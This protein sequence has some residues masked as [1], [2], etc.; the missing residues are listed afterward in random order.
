MNIRYLLFSGLLL[1]ATTVT[2]QQR[3]IDSLEQVVASMPGDTSKVKAMN[4]LVTKLQYVNPGRAAELVTESIALA[5]KIDYELGLAIAYRLRGV[6]YIDRSI[7]DSGKIFYDKAFNIV[8]ER[9]ERLYRRQEGLLRHN[10][11]VIF[12][13]RQEYD[14][15]TALYISAATVYSEIGEES[16]MFYP[17]VN[18]T[19]LYSFLKDNKRALM[20]AEEAL[21]AA[22]N[23]ND[24][25]KVILAINTLVSARFELRLFDN[26]YGLI[27]KN[28]NDAHNL[29]N[30]YAEGKA[31][32]LLAQYFGDGKKLYDSAIYYRK[33]SLRNMIRIGNQ[34]EIAGMNQNVGY[35]YKQLEM[36]DSAAVYLE[37]ATRQAKSLGLDHVVEYSISNLS[38]V[39][40]K[41]GNIQKAF[42]YLK[43]FVVVR[44]TILARNNRERVYE[45]EA[46][47]Q[48]AKKE[49]QIQELEADKKIGRLLNY[50]LLG[51]AVT[52]LVIFILSY[53]NYR[54]KQRL[55]QQKIIELEKERQLAATEAVLKGEEQ[56]R[57][58]LAK[59]LHDGLGGMLSG[60]KYSFSSMKGNL[61]MTPEN[62]KAFERSMDMLDSSIMEMRR[63]AHN[64][65]PE[66]L[67]RFGLDTAL[68]DFCND[69]NQ[70]GALKVSYQS[71]GMADMPFDQT[72]SITVYRIIQE[73]ISNTMKHASAKNAIVQVTRTDG[74]ISVTVEDDGKGFDTSVLNS[75]KGIGWTNIRHRVEF[76]KGTSDIHSEPGNGT[77][78]HIEFNV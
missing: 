73:L 55:Q 4:D 25:S 19:H 18:L 41:R 61:I 78:V 44:D 70:S 9:K 51:S 58:R 40:E 30:H 32:N 27:K 54:Q 46:R 48:N 59:D 67:V 34:Y 52:L 22:R 65:M 72:F 53:R 31:Q 75:V 3:V 5:D 23:M 12:H 37:E 35:D 16:L 36:Y 28:I 76:L 7:L 14:S 26:S 20:Y 47:F 33:Q 62:L 71:I 77:S 50:L 1:I 6:L 56:E 43:E 64:M 45:L 38:E 11:A 60:I 57:T 8:K 2:G 29:G 42:N 74:K 13:H 63:V 15:A 24:P 49:L 68:R 66:A 39:E 17:Y 69:I 21:K 10:Y